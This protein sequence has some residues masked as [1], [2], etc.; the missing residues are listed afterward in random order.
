MART[1]FDR[2]KRKPFFSNE[3]GVGKGM[4]NDS[5]DVMLVQLF[6]RAILHGGRALP[7]SKIPFILPP[8]LRDRQVAIT[9]NWDEASSDY[10]FQWE[11][12]Y[13]LMRTLLQMEPGDDP[14]E[15]VEPRTA[16]PG[17]V[18]PYAA[19]GEKIRAMNR[20]CVIMFG[21]DTYAI[22]ALPNTNLPHLLAK[23]LFY[24]RK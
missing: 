2:T 20:M 16:F 4:A 24:E 11:H 17:T 9:G 19:G 18:V 5:S 12:Q 6:L 23:E 1:Y 7:G 13:K 22:L 15:Y 10:L 8:A 3:R 21:E 14:A